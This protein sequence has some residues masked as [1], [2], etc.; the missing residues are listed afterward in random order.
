MS[1]TYATVRARTAALRK[2]SPPCFSRV[3]FLVGG[4]ALLAIIWVKTKAISELHFDSV[5]FIYTVFVTIF[6]L[7]RVVAARIFDTSSRS[8]AGSLAADESEF[9]PTVS[10]VIPCKNEGP[11]IAKT[12]QKCFAARYPR[13]LLE[14]IVINDG[15]TDNT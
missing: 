3:L 2:P 13:E 11:A 6:L 9:F 8:L 10:F 7:S 14:V 5:L 4:T 12:I 15:S 1:D